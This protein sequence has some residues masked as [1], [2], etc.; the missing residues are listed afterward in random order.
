MPEL[1]SGGPW[2]P[3]M[4]STVRITPLAWNNVDL[5][6]PSSFGTRACA[7]EL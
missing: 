5:V 7:A 2:C 6:G 3:S 1:V 4:V